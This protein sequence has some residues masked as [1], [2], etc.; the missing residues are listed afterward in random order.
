MNADKPG[1]KTTE[2]WLALVAT[3]VSLLLAAGVLPDTHWA[4]K[5][6]GI[7]SAALASMGY[8]AG[9]GNTKAAALTPV[10]PATLASSAPKPPGA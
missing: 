6:A 3:I 8:S 4:M 1:Y 5:V 7:V 2:F 9:R 10:D